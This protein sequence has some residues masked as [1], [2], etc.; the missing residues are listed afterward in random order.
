[1][2]RDAATR[3]YSELSATRRRRKRHNEDEAAGTQDK[4]LALSLCARPAGARPSQRRAERALSCLCLLL[5]LLALL[6]AAGHRPCQ[7]RAAR[8]SI[9]PINRLGN[10]QTAAKPLQKTTHFGRFYC[11]ETLRQQHRHV[12]RQFVV[13]VTVV[14]AI[15]VVAVDVA[16]VVLPTVFYFESSRKFFTGCTTQSGCQSRKIDN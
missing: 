15:V 16:L 12:T 14:V 11:D 3:R 4:A 9:S 8:A 5:L 7:P 6:P 10:W 1:M 13:V 2:R